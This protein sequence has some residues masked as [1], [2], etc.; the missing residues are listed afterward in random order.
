[1]TVKTIDDFIN[2]SDEDMLSQTEN[3]D[4]EKMIEEEKKEKRTRGSRFPWFH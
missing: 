2:L 1:M 3:L 4:F